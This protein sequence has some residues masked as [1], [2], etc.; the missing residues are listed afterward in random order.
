MSAKDEIISYVDSR[1][2]LYF[3]TSDQIWEYAELGLKEHKSAAAL[4]DILKN[5]GFQVTQGVS[6]LPTAFLAEFGQGKP[7]IA[8]LGEYD[9][10]PCLSQKAD[11]LERDPVQEGAPGPGC[12]HQL[13]GVGALAAAVAAKDYMKKH[14]LKGTIRYYGCP[15]EEGGCGKGFMVRDGLF[16]DVDAAFT[17]HPAIAYAPW[18]LSALSALSINFHFTGKAAHAGAAP[19]LGRSALD[20]CELMN[21]GVNYLRE[22]VPEEVRI[23]YAYLDAGGPAANVVQSRATLQYIIRAKKLQTALEVLERVK[24]VARGAAMMT[25]TQMECKEKACFADFVPN[26]VLSKLLGE[27]MEELG[28]PQYDAEDYAYAQQIRDVIKP[29]YG[30][31]DHR[32]TGMAKAEATHFYETHPIYDRVTPYFETDEYMSASTDVGDVSQ[33]IPTAQLRTPCFAIGTPGHSWQIVTQGKSSIAHKSILITGK[34]LALAGIKVLEDDSGNILGQ[35]K[36]E[37]MSKTGGKYVSPFPE[38]MTPQD[39]LDAT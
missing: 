17:W 33:V 10:L 38:G 28:A 39:V 20:A 13:L 11:K 34:T 12:G 8:Y 1:K 23:H 32:E 36:A 18:V 5:E 6:D 19:H 9:A 16:K 3:E 15:A 37:L 14:G 7:V 4:I 21:V 22:H 29:S 35:A 31:I 24:D 25:G 27:A 2:D 30:A 26:R